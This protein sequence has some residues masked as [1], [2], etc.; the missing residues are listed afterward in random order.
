MRLVRSAVPATVLSAILSAFS[1]SLAAQ[2]IAIDAVH[3]YFPPIPSSGSDPWTSGFFVDFRAELVALGFTLH[4]RTVFGA[5]ELQG[6]EA[7]VLMQ[8]HDAERYTDG[9]IAAIANFAENGGGVLILA[10][11]HYPL[12]WNFT[13]L[14]A[15]YG[16]VKGGFGPSPG[17]VVSPLLGHKITQGLAS[18]GAHGGATLFQIDSPSTDLTVLGDDHDLLA[19]ASNFRGGHDVVI[20]SCAQIFGYVGTVLDYGIE[21]PTNRRLLR[22]I[23]VNATAGRDDFVLM[24]Y[25]PSVAGQ[26]NE[27]RV[28]DADPNERV[29][30]IGGMQT[31]S[32]PLGFCGRVLGLQAPILLGSVVTDGQ[33]KGTSTFTVPPGLAGVTVYTQALQL[34]PCQLSN[35][36]KSSF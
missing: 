35:R 28:F 14:L 15:P 25:T 13:Q 16:C 4:P 24:P 1:G 36:L 12:D 34:Q 6:M 23:A 5:A 26:V 3:G 21:T 33:G 11:G 8:P 2:D 20:V 30:F 19:V 10:M 32:T 18:F 22:N 31:G 17:I 29:Y 9:E 27:L 7:V